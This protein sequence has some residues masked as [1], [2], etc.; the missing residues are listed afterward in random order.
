MNGNER[1]IVTIFKEYDEVLAASI[2]AHSTDKSF[3]YHFTTGAIAEARAEMTQQMRSSIAHRIQVFSREG[4]LE[5]SLYR[6]AK[7]DIQ[8]Q[9]SLEGTHVYLNEKFLEQLKGIPGKRD[10]EFLSSN[11]LDLIHIAAV[12]TASGRIVGYLE[13]LIHVD[14]SFLKDL[15]RRLEAEIAMIS[16]D[17]AS[18]IS[19]HEDFKAYP[20]DFFTSKLIGKTQL[21]FDLKVRGAPY[22]FMLSTL[23]WGEKKILLAVAASKVESQSLQKKLNYA[24]FTVVGVI[25]LL[26]VVISFFFSKLFFRPLNTLVQAIEKVSLDG[27]Q[28]EINDYSDTEIGV[29]ARS[30]N[31]MSKRV[32]EAQLK[33]KNNIV[34]LERA[35]LAIRETQGMLVHSAKMASLGQLVAGVAHELNNPIGFIYSNMDHL[36]DYSEK[37]IALIRVAEESPKDLLKQKQN[38]DFEYIVKDLP[39]LIKSC[40]EGA[41]RTRDIVIGLRNFSRIEETQTKEMNV[42]E[43]IDTTLSLLSGELK[44]RIDVHKDYGGVPLLLCNPSEI[45]QVLMNVLAN[46]AQAIDGTGSI[47]IRTY[48]SGDRISISIRDTGRGIKSDVIDRIF[49]PFFTTKSLGSGTGLGLSIS[50]GIIKKHGGDI[51]VTSKPGSGSD[52]TIELPLAASNGR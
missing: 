4:R 40:E 27:G 8:R 9:S 47:F 6:D 45:N 12:R 49:D 19:S 20:R 51:K 16:E 18:V 21:Y 29:L 34:E 44:D 31:E 35:N 41:K 33:L 32:H 3:I 36:R 52:F 39:K 2:K 15:S 50:Y 5:I 13:E 30:F 7:G 10:L 37:L 24:F 11:R 14:P 48:K 1:E 23:N 28:V 38:V 25:A 22:G 26:L 46:A 17:G 43:G 42:E